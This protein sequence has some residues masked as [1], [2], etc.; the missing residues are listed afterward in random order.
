MVAGDKWRARQAG[1]LA[2]A[3]TGGEGV[4]CGNDAVLLCLY[5]SGLPPL[6]RGGSSSLSLLTLEVMATRSQGRYRVGGGWTPPPTSRVGQV[7][8]KPL[9]A[10][11]A[12]CPATALPQHASATD[13]TI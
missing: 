7:L 11:K 9:N 6:P 13:Q 10:L 3:I 4:V 2:R 8:E 12:L 5:L 1:R